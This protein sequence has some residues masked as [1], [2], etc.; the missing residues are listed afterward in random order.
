MEFQ[1]RL[2]LH[3]NIVSFIGAVEPCATPCPSAR[4]SDSGAHPTSTATDLG[5]TA[6]SP[7]GLPSTTA[8]AYSL[9]ADSQNPYSWGVSAAHAAGHLHIPGPSASQLQPAAGV[10][11]PVLPIMGPPPHNPAACPAPHQLAIV[12]G[13]CKLGDLFN[14]IRKVGRGL[15]LMIV[16]KCGP[17]FHASIPCTPLP[18]Q[19][20]SHQWRCCLCCVVTFCL[21][22]PCWMRT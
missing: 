14:M 22:I 4:P 1:R 2:S 7:H 11:P 5:G 18:S 13:Y 8:D 12:M 16:G 3:P 17:S 19:P 9:D 20:R 21:S 10:G 6:F 15:L